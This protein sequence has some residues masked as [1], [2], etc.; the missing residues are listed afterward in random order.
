MFPFTSMPS[1][2]YSSPFFT[3]NWVAISFFSGSTFVIGATDASKKP[4]SA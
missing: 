3:S 1:T 2:K 4:R